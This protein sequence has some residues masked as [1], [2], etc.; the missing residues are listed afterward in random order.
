MAI[1]DDSVFEF[2]SH[3]PGQTRRLGIHLGGYLGQGDVVGLEGKLGSGKT[4]LVQG[5]AQGWGALDPVSSPTFMIVNEY[6][7]ADQE[8]LYHL[9]AYRLQNALD[10]DLLD[11]DRMLNQGPIVIEWAEK[12][13][14][15]LPESYLWINLK[16]TGME[17]RAMMLTSQGKRYEKIIEKLRRKIYGDF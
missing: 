4:T 8:R 11:F 16:Y 5:I 17:R 9:D 14:G 12:V 10:A 1:L 6:R 7:R 2:F 15:V 13:K 3:S